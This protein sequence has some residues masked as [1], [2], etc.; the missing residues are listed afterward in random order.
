MP[1]LPRQ[2]PESHAGPAAQANRNY[3]RFTPEMW[4]QVQNEARPNS[5]EIEQA[6]RNQE[7]TRPGY[8]G[9]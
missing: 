6:R 7:Q 9:L 3:P 1:F 8:R 2:T 5:G 4:E